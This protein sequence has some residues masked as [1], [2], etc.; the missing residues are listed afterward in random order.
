MVKIKKF[1]IYDDFKTG[2]L[3]K[4]FLL[5]GF[6]LIIL[7][8]LDVFILETKFSNILLSISILIISF[9]LIIYFFN[10][11]FNKL[12]TIAEEIEDEDKNKKK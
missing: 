9:G 3:Y 1:S 10:Y 8:L 11:Q 12:A 4:I 5:F 6:I 2:I 7:Y